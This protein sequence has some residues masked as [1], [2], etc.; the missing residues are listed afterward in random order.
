M[1]NNLKN[2]TYTTNGNGEP[3]DWSPVFF[4]PICLN[5]IKSK[6]DQ[7]NY[8]NHLRYG[9]KE[10]RGNKQKHVECFALKPDRSLEELTPHLDLKE[11]LNT[12]PKASLSCDLKDK[13]FAY[14]IAQTHTPNPLISPNWLNL[15]EHHSAI[16]FLLTKTLRL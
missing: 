3:R 15:H 16:Q 1:I 2:H 8:Y 11:K 12:E 5:N 14:D 9:C 6:I 10:E 7:D 4:A 13:P